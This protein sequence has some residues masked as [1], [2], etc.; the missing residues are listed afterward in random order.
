MASQA[1]IWPGQ[2]AAASSLLLLST[3][4]LFLGVCTAYVLLDEGLTCTASVKMWT[5][6]P[7]ENHLKIHGHFYRAHACFV[8]YFLMTEKL[9]H[10]RKLA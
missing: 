5:G 6:P 1:S 7:F 4:L 9:Q 8:K 3:V 2:A 10:I